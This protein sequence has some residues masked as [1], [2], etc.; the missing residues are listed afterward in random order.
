MG[1]SLRTTVTVFLT[2]HDLCA[3][4]ICQVTLT[5]PHATDGASPVSGFGNAYRSCGEGLMKESG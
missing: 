5:L 2:R 1:C 4:Q 3:P